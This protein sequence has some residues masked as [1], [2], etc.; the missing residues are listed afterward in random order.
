MWRRFNV[1]SIAARLFLSAAFWSLLI[2]L[3]AGV[4]LTAIYRRSSM[5]SFDQR[6]GVYLRVIVG[7]IASS[8]A[9]SLETEQM[10]EPAFQI[11]LSG[12]YWQVTRLDTPK[13]EIKASNSLFA[14]RL[15]QLAELGIP[16]DAD[17]ERKANVTGPDERRLRIVERLID[18]G[19]NGRYLVQVAASTEGVERDIS[20]FQLALGLT[21]TLLALALVGSTALQVRFGL[22][23]LRRLQEGVV[24]IRR[25]EAE[26]ITGEFPQDIAPLADELNLLIGSNREIVERA[27]TQVGNLAHAL[28]TPLSILV[29]EADVEHGTF[30]AKVR[31][32]A[33]VMSH[34]VRH[35]LDRARAAARAKTTGAAAE[36]GPVINSL[37][38]T[39]EKI[40]AD[41]GL[42]FSAE[43][44]D[45]EMRFRGERQDLQEMVGN[46]VDNAGKWTNRQIR[47]S[48]RR[49]P[50][51]GDPSWRSY[52]IICIDDDGPGLPRELRDAAVQ[53][54]RRLDK[55]KP[56]TGLG[57]SIV[58]DLV[59]VYDGSFSL[60][61]SPLG[62]LRATLRLPAI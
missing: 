37:V 52:M 21:F 25:G 47:V 15:P 49:D 1:H 19:D 13:P 6:L 60:D 57:L 29:N 45:P 27:R 38:R 24:A 34:Q 36:V 50:S 44:Q 56:G 33:E 2:L 35:Y 10:G 7:D 28:K 9:E 51:P 14:A 16:I 3:V 20:R 48:A 58:V 41:R 46:L 54:G 43:V 59:S 53:R 12:W 11:T 22:R 32:Q 30:G 42:S 39:F 17:G 4:T 61:D 55:S 62:G 23:P 40:Y 26:R 18:V 5:D 8:G 31:E